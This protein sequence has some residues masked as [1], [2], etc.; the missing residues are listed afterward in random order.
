M[1]VVDRLRKRYGSV[2]AVDDL[3]FEVRQGKV[4]ALLGP[5]GAGKT[6]SLRI[7]LGLSRPDAGS[8]TF[9]GQAY[10]RLAQPIRQVGALIEQSTFHPGRTARTHL[11]ALARASGLSARR[12]EEVLDLVDLHD[13]GERRV[14]GYSTGM[15]QR[16]GLACA[17]LGDPATLVLDEPQNG[18]DPQGTRWLRAFLRRLA[19]EGRTVLVS[20]HLLSEMEQLADDVVIV[21][22]G[23]VV[24]SSS[25]TQLRLDAGG[26]PVRRLEDVFLEL[27]GHGAGHDVVSQAAS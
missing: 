27:T 26:G 3:S 18:L 17:L 1:I 12:A 20:S 16:L 25:L 19:D 21:D 5:N 23:R 8:A 11:G 14:G 2:Q 6:T 9:D 13:A 15:R 4:T 10:S 24:H 7:L 22:N